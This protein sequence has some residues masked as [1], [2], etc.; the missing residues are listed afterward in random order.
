[1]T[2]FRTDRPILVG[3]VHLMPLPGSPRFGGD[4]VAVVDAAKRDAEALDAGG[5]DA[6]MVEN[7][8]DVPFYNGSVPSETVSGITAGC[9]AVR[10]ASN[11]P[12]G[13]NVLR[14]D[15]CSAVGIAACVGAAFIR[16]NVLSGA[17]VTDQ[18]IIEGQAADVMRARQALCPHVQVWADVDVK[19]SAPL[20]ARPLSE[21]VA[22]LV[23]RGLAD[24]VIVSGGGTGLATSPQQVD[25]VASMTDAPVAIGSGASMETIG[26]YPAAR[27]FIAGTA[28]KQNGHVDA[29]VDV[30]RVQAFADVLS[31]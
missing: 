7:F 16:I 27:A 18:G 17:R 21:E 28:L 10:D 26:H 14:N 20:A 13:V 24:V 8:G 22:D 6:I 15:G 4:M 19:H 25:E 1:M 23:K 9:L 29:P 11:L 2:L 12:I 3:M 5:C 31:S 30:A